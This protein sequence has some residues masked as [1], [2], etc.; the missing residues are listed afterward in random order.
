MRLTKSWLRLSLICCTLVA[1]AA[2][3]S[4]V[5]KQNSTPAVVERA[6]ISINKKGERAYKQRP[7]TGEVVTYYSSGQLST[8]DMFVNGRRQGY[9]KR[10]FA[11]GVLAYESNYVS[12]VREGVEKSWW[13]N[14]NRRTKAVFVKGKKDGEAFSWYRNGPKFKKSNYSS[15]L[16][17]GLQQGWRRNGKLFTN[18]EYKNGR[19]YGLKK[20][21]SCVGLKDETVT[22]QYYQTQAN[23]N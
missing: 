22:L 17:T 23:A 10:W 19:I 20:A 11:N 12:G 21:N 16:P 15:G 2:I 13:D 5:W 6:A 3:G 8:S 14:G 18:Y 4:T 7:Y 9:A 1:S